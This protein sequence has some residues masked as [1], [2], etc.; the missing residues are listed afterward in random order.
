MGYA[1]FETALGWMGVAWNDAGVT[2]VQLPEADRDA[3]ERRLAE[4]ARAASPPSARRPAWVGRLAE[5]LAKHA[6]GEPQSFDDVPL[7][8]RGVPPFHAEVYRVA[9]SIPAGTTRAYGEI[10]SALGKPGAARAV[11]QAMAKNP[12][13]VVVPCHRVTAAGGKPGGFSAY[14]GLVTKDRLLAVEGAP[15]LGAPSSAGRALPYDAAEA[16]RR[17]AAADAKLR[18]VIE[19][20]GPP[21]LTLE[22]TDSTVAALAKAIVYQQLNGKAA[23]T[24]HDRLLAALPGQRVTAS[25]LDATSDEAL[26]A[27]GISRSK[28]LALRDLAARAGRREVPSFAALAA[29][30]DEA[31]VDVLT[32][33]RGVGRWT[34]EMLLIFRLGRPD[35]LPLG[36]YGVRKG[37]A[38]AYR[39]EE[40]PTPAELARAGQRWAPFRSVA[41]WYLWRAAEA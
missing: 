16:S 5:K 18:R 14:G 30:D 35:V 36:D 31:I 8:T 4:R 25:S 27:A 41:S 23:K 29:M 10:A 32:R 2:A 38:A 24:I 12:F 33:V 20:V 3:T 22:P 40:L 21:R 37:F 15:A 6:R 28:A 7:D 11:G 19:R 34:V 17:L 13:P 1:L 39:R 9:R 26:R